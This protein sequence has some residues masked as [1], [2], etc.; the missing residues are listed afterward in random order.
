MMVFA[1]QA[2]PPFFFSAPAAMATG[3]ARA[4]PPRGGD[5]MSRL[6]GTS[7]HVHRT[8]LVLA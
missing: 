6:T 4:E 8:L 7:Q 5:W 2:P 3:M 1:A